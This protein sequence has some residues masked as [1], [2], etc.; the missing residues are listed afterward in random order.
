MSKIHDLADLGQSVWMDFIR[1]SFLTSGELSTLID[2]GVRGMTSNPTIFEKAIAGSSR[3]AGDTSGEYDVD[4]A[5]LAEDGKSALEIF[6]SLAI[7]DIKIATDL[8]RPV[9]KATKGTDGYVSIEVS[10]NLAHQTEQTVDEALRLWSKI[11]RPN[12]MVKI[13]A[14]DQ[15]L[16]AITRATAAGINVNITLIFS[17]K[18]YQQVM[19]AFLKGLEERLAAGQPIDHIASVASF[20][21][22]R[23]DTKVDKRLD[24]ILREG[25]PSLILAKSLQGKAAVA[26]ARIAYSLFRKTFEGQR[27]S[28]LQA[29]GAHLQRPLWASTSTKNPA[30]SDIL[31]VQ[32]LI[33]PH[34]VNTMPQK[35]VEDF[36][37]HGEVRLTLEDGLDQANGVMEKLEDL[38]VSMDQVTQELEDEGVEA[39]ARSFTSL[40][41]SIDKRRQSVG[42]ALR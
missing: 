31:Y 1:R 26:N 11:D 29:K 2:L 27:F 19:D 25:G 18:R 37:D 33:G 34:T 22:S 15:G 38:G 13:P 42:D 17:L 35:T 4:L 39:F 28:A 10:P 30:Y 20:F 7:D 14:T 41:E 9:F 36:L 5:R 8:F 23:V 32:E 12:L 6:E 40:I 3:F 16:P 21:V 24:D